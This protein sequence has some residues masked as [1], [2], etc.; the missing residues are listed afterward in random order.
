M[1]STYQKTQKKLLP[2]R[3]PTEG[4]RFLHAAGLQLLFQLTGLVARQLK[5]A[6]LGVEDVVLKS[7]PS[8]CVYVVL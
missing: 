4:A 2:L 6:A 5:A 3:P 8:C 1:D 7:C